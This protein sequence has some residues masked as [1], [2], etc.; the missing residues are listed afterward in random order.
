MPTIKSGEFHGT[1]EFYWNQSK[2]RQPNNYDLIADSMCIAVYN[3]C[4]DSTEGDCWE[5]H[6]PH[7]EAAGYLWPSLRLPAEHDRRR[8]VPHAGQTV[9]HA[10]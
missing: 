2:S 5:P 9:T 6:I 4:S 3:G 8:L 10:T 1:N 7:Y